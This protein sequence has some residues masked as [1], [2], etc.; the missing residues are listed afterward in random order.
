M[1][2]AWCAFV[3]HF[4]PGQLLA[5]VPFKILLVFTNVPIAPL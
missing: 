5:Q 4:N 2:E 3:M 1:T